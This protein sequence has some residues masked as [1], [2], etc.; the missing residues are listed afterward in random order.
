MNGDI[1]TLIVLLIILVVFTIILLSGKGAMWVA[2]Y[3]TASEMEKREID[4]ERL[5]KSV[6]K[7]M[8][9]VDILLLAT[10]ILKSLQVDSTYIYIGIGIA[11]TVIVILFVIWFNVS[12]AGKSEKLR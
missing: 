1:V 7:L 3:G 10:I 4:P 9:M 11:S 12:N 5:S 6:G 2:G 8:V